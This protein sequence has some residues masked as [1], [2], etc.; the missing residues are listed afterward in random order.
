MIPQRRFTAPL[1]LLSLVIAFAFQF[2]LQD[3]SGQETKKWYRGN[4]HT[5]SLW[6]DGNDFPEMIAKWYVDH[7]YHFLALTDHNIL[8]Q[9]EKWMGLDK[10]QE[11]G[12]KECLKKYLDAFGEDWVKSKQVDGM[13]HVRLSPLDEFRGKFEKPGEFLMIE[14]EEISDS[15]NG[16]P[17]HMNAANLEKVLQ[18]TGGGSVREVIDSNLRAAAEHAAKSGRKVM[19]H[20]NHPNFGWAITAEDLAAVTR[21]RFFEVYNGH[22]GVNQLGDKDHPSIERM[23]DIINTLR[24]DKL[25]SPP[26]FGMA[27]DDSHKY[28]GKPGSQPGRGW[29]MVKAGELSA[30]SLITAMYAGDFYSSSGVE[31]KSV[32]FDKTEKTLSLEIVGQEGVTYETRFVGTR[33]GYNDTSKVRQDKEGKDL[34]STRTYSADVGETLAT[35]DSLTASYKLTGDELYVRAIITASA[36]HPN[37]SYK[38]QKQSAWT[39]PVGWRKE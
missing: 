24:I 14:A 4:L 38:G 28:H 23:W 3:A 18:P 35:S 13:R 39:Q 17:I 31:L 10:I 15:F 33:K 7:D 6:S 5:H 27:T 37:P 19:V 16:L 11:R 30:D 34:R 1:C 32:K 26:I 20:L 2:A 21:E 8:S 22:P 25:S 29:V 12:G 9:G 36:D